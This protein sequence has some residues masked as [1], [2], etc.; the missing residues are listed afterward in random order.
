MGATILPSSSISVTPFLDS[1]EGYIVREI[2]ETSVCCYFSRWLFV[3]VVLKVST[4][5]HTHAR[6]HTHTHTNT[7]T[8][9]HTHKHTHKQTQTHTHTHK[10]THTH[11]PEDT[12][13]N[14]K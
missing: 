4:N 2:K 13:L 3:L 6:T 9:K 8:Q 1:F 10:Q 12:V 7:H 14:S 11:T 5:T